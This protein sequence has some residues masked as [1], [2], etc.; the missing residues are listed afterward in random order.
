LKNGLTANEILEI[1]NKYINKY[2]ERLYQIMRKILY[3]YTDKGF[4]TLWNRNPTLGRSSILM[5]FIGDIKKDV[6]DPTVSMSIGVVT[7]F[8]AFKWAT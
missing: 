7:F 3:D 2:D 6:G 8:N 4:P 1:F 5:L